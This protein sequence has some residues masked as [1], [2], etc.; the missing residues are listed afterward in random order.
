MSGHPEPAEYRLVTKSGDIKWVRVSSRLVYENDTIARIRGVMVDIT[1]RRR[2]EEAL[3]QSE[4]RYR[5]LAENVTD[6]IWTMDLN[7]QCTYISPSVTRQRGFTVEEAMA[8]T[9]EESLTPASLEAAAKA[10]QE[11]LALEAAGQDANFA[12]RPVDLEQYCRD[13]STV[14]TEVYATLLRD[15]DGQAIGILGV[16]RDVTERKQAEAERR[17]MEQQLQLSGRLAAVGELAAGVAHELNNP[18]AAVQGFAQ[19]LAARDDLEESMRSDVDTIH[20]EAKRATKITANLLSFARKHESEKRPISINEVVE[21][22]IELHAYRMRVNNIEVLT[23]LA[24]GLPMTMADFHQ[25]QQVCVNIITNAEQAMTAAHG[26]G[27]LSVRTETAGEY[28]RMALSDDG[29]GIPEEYLQRVFDPFFT[30]KDVG[31]GTGL[32]LSIC[33]GIVED[34]GGL[35]R[36]ESRP[37]EGTTFVIEIP[38]VSADQAV[39]E[40]DALA[41]LEYGA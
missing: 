22:C 28:V 5:L 29:P 20:R 21:S 38:I 9:P 3:K 30:T 34:H 33:Y 36:A 16:A 32:G 2:A 31:K 17:M 1:G 4:R 8:L 25:L 6:V 23:E 39:A 7:W 19:L 12:A 10:I 41:S 18:L 35:I 14:W 24:P 37:D 26:R 15:Q 13:G 11:A 40:R 27:T